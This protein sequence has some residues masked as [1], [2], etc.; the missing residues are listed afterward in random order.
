MGS[1]TSPALSN[2]VNHHL[3][4]RLLG[5]A[6]KHKGQYTRY[7]DDI[8]LS[9]PAEGKFLGHVLRLLEEIIQ[10]E[11]Y[12]IQ[13]QKGVRVLR[14]YQQQIV[15]G[16]VVNDRVRLPRTTR[17]RLRALRHQAQQRTLDSRA[18]ARLRGYEALNRMVE[19]A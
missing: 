18:Y 12:Q 8:T 4:A 15:T 5:L 6:R 2:V 11:G 10:A 7:A 19:Q 1:P 16:L 14:A 17:R 9:F 13:P 3:D